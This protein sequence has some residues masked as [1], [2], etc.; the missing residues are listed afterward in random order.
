MA[1]ETWVYTDLDFYLDGVSAAAN[2]IHLQG[3]PIISAV[4]ANIETVDIPGRNG[5][6]HIAD[7][8]YKDR[9]ITFSC[10]AAGYNDN[11]DSGYYVGGDGVYSTVT[12][13]NSFLFPT[14]PNSGYLG[15][16]KLK[17]GYSDT[18]WRALILNG[19]EIQA[20]LK[21]LAPFEIVFTVDPIRR[22]AADDSEVGI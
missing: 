5:A 15:Y 1:S 17:I 9:T 16:R 21:T 3:E 22:S 13:I 6:L 11:R 14:N 7:G 8:T 10:Y 18:Y 4:E 20:R 19:G 2:G 12:L